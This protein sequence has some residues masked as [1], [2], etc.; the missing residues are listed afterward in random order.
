MGGCDSYNI[1]THVHI[2]TSEFIHCIRRLLIF[3]RSERSATGP[4]F[5]IVFVLSLIHAP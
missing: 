4:Y 5:F 3:N 2:I 1:F